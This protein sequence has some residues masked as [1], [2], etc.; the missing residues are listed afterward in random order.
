[1]LKKNYLPRFYNIEENQK[2][3]IKN[4]FDI[5]DMDSD[6]REY[7]KI[8]EEQM[9]KNMFDFFL[10][11]MFNIYNFK[12]QKTNKIFKENSHMYDNN[13]EYRFLPKIYRNF[14][15]QKDLFKDLY[16]NG[17]FSLLKEEKISWVHLHI[18]CV[19]IFLWQMAKH[20]YILKK[21]Y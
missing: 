21:I 10:F 4:I 14:H 17:D 19:D 16:N 20:G 6:G 1:M 18:N 11:N 12:L 8:T 13:D 5:V 15:D 3:F 7:Y 2:L 9:L